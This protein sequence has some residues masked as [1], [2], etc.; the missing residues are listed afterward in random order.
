MLNK[1]L[2]LTKH[3]ISIP[4]TKNNPSALKKVL[5]VTKR[6]LK[7]FAIEKFEKDGEPSLLAYNTHSRPKKFKIILNAHLDIIPPN[8]KNYSLK[9]TKNKLLGPGVL[10]M[11]AATAVE[12]LVFKELA[13]KLNYPL[14]IQL[15]T[16]EEIGGFKGTKY[17]I[18]KG[19]KAEFVIIGE[20]TNL[21]IENQA[22]GIIWAKIETKG[23]SAHAAYPWKGNNAI[24]KTKKLLDILE[25]EFPLPKKQQWTTTLN[26]SKISTLN[27][28]FNKIP[29]DCEIWLDIRYL[30]KES[31]KTLNSLKKII[32]KKFK[33]KII[34]KEPGF[35]TSKDNKYIKSLQ[36]VIKKIKGKQSQIVPGYGSSDLRHFSAVN[37]PGIEFGPI[38]EGMGSNNEWVDIKS[39]EK[40][41]QI[42]KNFLMKAN[43]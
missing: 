39:L 43:L 23:K 1:I 16:D 24:W 32:P 7:G 5:K 20:P 36:K 22:K 9:I 41:Y 11:K 30:P 10:D 29:E 6:E 13:Y 40:Y 35:Y 8:K 2:L 15:V 31:K 26:L 33:T 27:D 3:L 18:G 28:T 37:S 19:V 38:G 14:G 12:I 4:S 34:L 17:Q 42:L 25:K 21:N